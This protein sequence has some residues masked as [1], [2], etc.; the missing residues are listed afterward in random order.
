MKVKSFLILLVLCFPL[1]SAKI[2]HTFGSVKGHFENGIWKDIESGLYSGKIKTEYGSEAL[3]YHEGVLIILDEN[4]LLEIEESKN[5]KLFSGRAFALTGNEEKN[6]ESLKASIIFNNALVGL[7]CEEGVFS[8][9]QED[10]GKCLIESKNGEFVYL[11]NASVVL[12]DS[13]F[14]HIRK[15]STEYEKYFEKLTS[16]VIYTNIKTIPL[17]ITTPKDNS[18]F[19]YGFYN[20]PVMG[21]SLAFIPVKLYINGEI[22][23]RAYT[24]KKG[25]FSVVL[26]TFDYLNK[27]EISI[28]VRVDSFNASSEK[29]FILK[30]KSERDFALLSPTNN[31]VVSGKALS[32]HGLAKP[33][34][35]VT[36]ASHKITADKNGRF[37]PASILLREG[38]NI[39]EIIHE[40]K[41]NIFT[42]NITVV[43]D[44]NPPQVLAFNV[45]NLRDGNVVS[46]KADIE[47]VASSDTESVNINGLGFKKSNDIFIGSV[48]S[49]EDGQT[50]LNITLTDKAGNVTTQEKKIVFKMSAPYLTVRPIRLPYINGI[51]R[52]GSFITIE[53]DGQKA[54]N[55]SEVSGAFSFDIRRYISGKDKAEITVYAEDSYGH[56]SPTFVST[57]KCP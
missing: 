22:R 44:D 29:E 13:G 26:N 31:E 20:I 35:K 47:I 55:K 11:T 21:I 38:T 42:T 5:P 6:I 51:A 52:R 45:L 2:I 53:V 54:I 4:S 34:S 32:L 9:K 16:S 10:N 57:N 41:E 56:K 17:S 24:D 12:T 1:L 30:H 8:S 40:D 50:T 14:T 36:F 49:A 7:S 46:Y 33:Q 37:G 48:I 15:N 23:G 43:I 39:L 25:L 3:V 28:K 19:G 27:D 18:S